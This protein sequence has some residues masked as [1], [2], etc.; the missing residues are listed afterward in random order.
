MKIGRNDPCH[1][2][3]GKKYK[4]CCL[5]K[6][7]ASKSAAVPQSS[8]SSPLSWVMDDDHLD[9]DSNRVVD[10][11]RAGNL[12]EAEVAANALLRDYPEVHDGLERLGMVY[13]ARGELKRA[14]DYYRQTV[15]FME[16]HD[17]YDV[18]LIA[19]IRDQANRLDPPK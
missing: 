1:C 9:D 6:D 7:N 3:S 11:I 4:K 15:A 5:P 13:E 17:G 18:E 19:S 2:G 16:S 10:L 14:A 8:S 12:D